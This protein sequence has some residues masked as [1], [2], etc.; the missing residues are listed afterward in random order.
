[1]FELYIP[2]NREKTN[3]VHR[4]YPFTRRTF[5]K[6]P[7]GRERKKGKKEIYIYV[8]YPTSRLKKETYIV[9]FTITR[10]EK[11]TSMFLSSTFF[12]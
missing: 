12:P 8:V 10:S 11:E 1:M 2:Y 5:W 7:K 9:I 6:I 3:T 4:E